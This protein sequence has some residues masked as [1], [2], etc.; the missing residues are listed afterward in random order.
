MAIIAYKS[1]GCYSRSRT[2]HDG[3]TLSVGGMTH[4]RRAHRHGRPTRENASA[5]GT[6]YIGCA[7]VPVK[8]RVTKC[9]AAIFAPRTVRLRFLISKHDF[10]RQFRKI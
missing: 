4:G 9:R 10:D 5:H 1:N 8:A 7:I 2:V 6:Q 3:G